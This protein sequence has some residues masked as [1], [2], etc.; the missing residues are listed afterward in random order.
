MGGRADGE[1]YDRERVGAA[2]D[3]LGSG[4]DPVGVRPEI[5]ASWRRSQGHG[6]ARETLTAPYD[7]R[8]LDVDSPFVRTADPVLEQL[9][10]DLTHSPS[11][12]V[13]ADQRGRIL[14]RVT[15]D[16]RFDSRLDDV[17]VAPGFNYS[18]RYVGTNALGTALHD[19]TMR[20]VHEREHFNDRLARLCCSAAPVRDPLTGR[21][22]GAVGIA[23]PARSGDASW[24]ALVRQTGLLVETRLF[25]SLADGM[26]DLYRSY[27]AALRHGRYQVFALGSDVLRAPPAVMQQLG[28][29]DHDQLWTLAL[30]AL[31]HRQEA[32][33]QV[34]LGDGA[35]VSARLRGFERHGRLVGALGELRVPVDPPRA[36]RAVRPVLPLREYAGWSAQTRASAVALRRLAQERHPACVVG[37]AGTGKATM[38]ELVAAAVAAGRVLLTVSAEEA[39]GAG[40]ERVAEQLAAGGPVL[41]RH[42][43][44]LGRDGLAPL[45]AAAD[46]R[47]WLAITWRG[48]PEE[49]GSAVRGTPLRVVSLPP[50]RSRPDDVLR[51]VDRLLGSRPTGGDVAFSPALRER[52]RQE[53]W[54]TNLT[55]LAEVVDE[56]LASRH[57]SVV[58]V[59]D[60]DEVVRARVRRRLT[61]VEWLLRGAIV[62]A[63]RAHGGN[64]DRAATSLGMSRASIYRKIKSFDI[65]VETVVHG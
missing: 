36:P 61:P 58:D 18:E 53:P 2:L 9:V 48:E 64:K 54:P 33:V 31:A 26:R 1:G 29:L 21:V 34:T 28:S 11:C 43:E 56:L 38:V 5:T 30:D 42:V 45:L 57:G 51:A 41:V 14:R 20:V 44:R 16:P 15:A 35:V 52:L 19:R 63:L 50:L 60:L 23:A 4:G 59:A 37:E 25:D 47:G 24:A 22:L 17:L 8:A 12:V 46:P 40:A 27:L 49:A 13:L 55:G 62:D 32:E 6:V 3:A 39:V 10:E 65:D 7:E